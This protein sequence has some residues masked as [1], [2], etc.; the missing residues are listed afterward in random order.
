MIFCV[1]PPVP[2]LYTTFLIIQTDNAEEE[3]ESTF[4]IFG[5]WGQTELLSVISLRTKVLNFPHVQV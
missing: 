4:G 3:D 2:P 5:R 1:F